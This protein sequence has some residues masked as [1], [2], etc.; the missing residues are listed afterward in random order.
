[1][2]DDNEPKKPKARVK[3]PNWKRG[4]N[5]NPAG[6]RRG[7]KHHVTLFAEQL[8]SGEAEGIVRKTFECAPAGAAACLKL[9]MDRILPAPRSRRINFPLPAIGSTSAALSALTSL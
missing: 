3:A 8:L 7:S 4:Q 1:M 9:C 2:T 5:G 6:M